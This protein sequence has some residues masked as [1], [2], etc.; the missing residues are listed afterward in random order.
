MLAGDG[1]YLV[2]D[3]D[4]GVE[5]LFPS[6]VEVVLQLFGREFVAAGL[7]LYQRRPR[8]GT[9]GDTNEAIRVELLLPELKRDLDVALDA[10]ARGAE[11]L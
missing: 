3:G 4:D 8:R 1:R 2:R 6:D 10:A 11:R 9:S 5:T 7:D